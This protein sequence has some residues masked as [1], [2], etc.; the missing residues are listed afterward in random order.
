MILDCI[1]SKKTVAI[2]WTQALEQVMYTG[3]YSLPSSNKLMMSVKCPLPFCHSNIV[4]VLLSQAK[5]WIKY[6][7][8]ESRNE[9]LSFVDKLIIKCI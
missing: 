8:H 6:Y 7:L 3:G 2:I 1:I 9:D 4:T 5:K